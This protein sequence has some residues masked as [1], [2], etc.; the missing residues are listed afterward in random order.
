M[1]NIY[2][3]VVTLDNRG[4]AT[5]EMPDWFEALNSDFRY[6][7]TSIGTAGPSLYIN[8][9]MHERKFKIAGGLADQKVS[10]Q[11]TGIR[12]GAYVKAH[13][14]RVEEDKPEDDKE[15]YL[16][17]ELFGQPKEKSVY[18]GR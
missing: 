2:D 9:E 8:E 5:L 18:P 1:K 12:Q 10:W 15:T 4:A 11:V 13:R 3:G 17:P 6:Q 14:S 16:H 7:L